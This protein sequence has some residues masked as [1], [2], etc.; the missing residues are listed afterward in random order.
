MKN[1]IKKAAIAATMVSGLGIGLAQ[2]DTFQALLNIVTPIAVQEAT[3]M[4]LGGIEPVT[5]GDTCVLSASGDRTGTA[6]YL[7]GPGTGTNGVLDVTGT[8]GLTFEV[9]LGAA[10]SVDGMQFTPSLLN[11]GNT[12]GSGSTTALDSISLEAGHQLTMGGTLEITNVTTAVASTAPSIPYDVTV[13][14]Q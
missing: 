5:N 8:Q 13:A 7:A 9:I 4:N 6:C 1:S 11:N 3:Q 2:A 12:S 14:Y 10:Q